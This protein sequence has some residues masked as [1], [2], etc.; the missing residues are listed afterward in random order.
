MC[1][2]HLLAGLSAQVA[3][4][5]PPRA[6]TVRPGLS[7]DD[8]DE[9]G[10]EEE[11]G[12][13]VVV[14]TGGGRGLGECVAEIYG[15]KGTNVAVLDLE[16]EKGQGEREGVRMYKCDVGNRAEVE[17]VWAR[18]VADLG[19]PTVL[20]NNAAV[21]HGKRFLD[22][23]MEDVERTFRTNTLSHYHLASL[24]LPPLLSRPGGGTLVT[25][26]S[27]L[28]RLGASQLS[29]YT[30]SKAALLA[31]H[32][33]LSAELATTPNIKTILVT[34]GQLDTGLFAGVRVGWV[35]RFFGPVVEVREL[36]VKLVAMID[37][38]EGGV[39][40]VPAYARWIAWMGVLPAGLQKVLR[41]WSGVDRAMG[42]FG[43]KEKAS[44]ER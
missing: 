37:S 17:R 32:A 39:L 1:A 2:C 8:E 27:V 20:I 26:S 10:E 12:E 36:A 44:C 33:S 41:D 7:A 3:R 19:T 13:E 28:A 42:G 40:A 34:P 15:I 4:N 43:S 24:F 16:V 6:T 30:A 29:D 9:D 11:G 38:G 31:F 14:V 18:V 21:V 25:V 5:G 22:L 23:T 35:G